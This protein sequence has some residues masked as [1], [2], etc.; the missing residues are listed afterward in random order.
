MQSLKSAFGIFSA[1]IPIIYCAGL[2]YY[3]VDGSGSFDQAKENGLAP[4]VIGLGVVGLLFC[5]PLFYR[6]V[7]LFFAVR[8]SPAKA[9]ASANTSGTN[10]EFDADAVFARYMAKQAKEAG[11]QPPVT[12]PSS[13]GTPPDRPA[14]GRRT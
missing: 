7:K 2:I 1:L 13:E 12:R 14:F 3:F 5:I 9:R 10:E 11:S 4:T 8:S 6:L